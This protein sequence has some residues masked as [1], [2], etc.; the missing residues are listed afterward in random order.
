M[1]NLHYIGTLDEFQAELK[2]TPTPLDITRGWDT[3]V[4]PFAVDLLRKRVY[5]IED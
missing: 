2:Y 5:V 4:E 3:T 1:L